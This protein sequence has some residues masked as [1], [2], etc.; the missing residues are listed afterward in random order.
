MIAAALLPL[1]LGAGCISSTQEVTLLRGQLPALPDG[2]LVNE[3][4]E[5]QAPYPVEDLAVLTVRFT[6]GG[7]ES[8]LTKL[9]KHACYYGGDTLYAITDVKRSAVS[10]DLT[11]KLA[12]R[13][14]Q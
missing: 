7:R 12:R 4:A 13:T 8:A 1:A 14:T 2:C 5:P 6:S 9:K 3:V 10:F 11:A